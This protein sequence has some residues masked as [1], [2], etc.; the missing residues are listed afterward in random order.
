MLSQVFDETDEQ[1]DIVASFR[2]VTKKIKI[3]PS[4]PVEQNKITINKLEVKACFKEVETTVSTTPAGTT[5]TRS[6]TTQ[7]TTTQTIV[8]SVATTFLPG[9]PTGECHVGIL[10]ESAF[11]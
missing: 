7:Y 6:T 8:T 1:G 2:V 3:V 9:E 4:Q 11:L 10:V 5:T